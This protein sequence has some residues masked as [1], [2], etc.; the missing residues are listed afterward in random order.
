MKRMRWA[1]WT[2]TAVFLLMFAVGCSEES[3]DEEETDLDCVGN[4]APQ[5]DGPYLVKGGEIVEGEAVFGVNETIGVAVD[6]YDADCNLGGGRLWAAID[7]NDFVP[8]VSVRQN[9]PCEG[10][11][12]ESV[13]GFDIRLQSGQHKVQVALVDAC[14]T[15]SKNAVS[16]EFTVEN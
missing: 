5:V 13:L 11:F 8:M 15:A 2:V 6:F 10:Y 4:R 1:I 7:K 3:D 12:P 16:V 9:I 14:G